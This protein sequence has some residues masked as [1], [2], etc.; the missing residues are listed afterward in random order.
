M[1]CLLV[2]QK[3]CEVDK[4]ALAVVAPR[5]FKQLFESW[6]LPLFAHVSQVSS[7]ARRRNSSEGR[8]MI[9]RTSDLGNKQ[10]AVSSGRRNG[11]REFVVLKVLIV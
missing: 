11:E 9:V 1:L 7:T 6:V 2:I 5:L 8:N 4:G 10:R 3:D